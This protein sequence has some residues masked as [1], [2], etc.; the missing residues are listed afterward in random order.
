MISFRTQ[1]LLALSGLIVVAL[2]SITWVVI[3]ATRA[4]AD[5]FAARELQVAEKVFNQQLANNQRQ[6]SGRARLLAEDF[7]FRRAIAT[8]E[9]ET[10]ISVLANHGDR[11]GATLVMMAEP[12]GRIQLASHNLDLAG[13]RLRAAM[14]GGN[15]VASL[16]LVSE[17]EA[18]QMALVPVMAPNLIAWVGLG[19]A[20]DQAALESLKSITKADVGLQINGRFALSTLGNEPAALTVNELQATGA[21]LVRQV[22]LGDIPAEQ[23]SAFL[24]AS[25]ADLAE[26]FAQL[27]QQMQFIAFITLIVAIAAAGLLARSITRPIGLLVD[28]AGRIAGGD[29]EQPVEKVRG[30]ELGSLARA[31]NALQLAVKSREARIRHQATH[32][33]ES[34]LLNSYGL[35]RELNDLFDAGKPFA[36]SLTSLENFG[37]ISD[38]YGYGFVCDYLPVLTAQL[39]QRLAT[40]SVVARVARD[41]LAVVSFQSADKL[42]A[43]LTAAMAEPW[44]AGPVQL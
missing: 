39:N 10:L 13:D 12:D 23:L 24:L 16:I 37:R 44:R 43:T 31:L 22:S 3:N 5:N 15:D 11:V 40:D 41:Q 9:Q 35:R 2:V 4:A 18:F 30:D 34:G 42:Q 8:G 7:G 26:P 27:Q 32:D 38:L 19:F 28:A 6:L 17:G 36:F 33:E 1:L 21:W 29:Y 25:P 20:I 14:V